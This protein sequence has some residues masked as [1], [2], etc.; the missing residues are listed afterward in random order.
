MCIRVEPGDEYY[1]YSMSFDDRDPAVSWASWAAQGPTR[2]AAA[3][4]EC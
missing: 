4:F 3:E 1:E 2:G